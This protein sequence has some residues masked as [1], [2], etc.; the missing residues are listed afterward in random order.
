MFPSLC[1]VV[2]MAPELISHHLELGHEDSRAEK[3]QSPDGSPVASG[4]PVVKSNTPGETRL[5][6]LYRC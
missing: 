5:S 1:V 2:H 3:K 6:S 4:S